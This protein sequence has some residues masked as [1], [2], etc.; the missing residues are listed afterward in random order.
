[1]I[2]KSGLTPM[3]G[4]LAYIAIELNEGLY[5]RLASML[6]ERPRSAKFMVN[7]VA[8]SVG[9]NVNVVGGLAPSGVTVP[10]FAALVV[11]D[12]RAP[13]GSKAATPV[14]VWAPDSI[15]TV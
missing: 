8:G 9:V 6:V 2:S 5:L 12:I 10:S 15:S 11:S 4:S 3:L 7:A 14:T 13:V 1:V